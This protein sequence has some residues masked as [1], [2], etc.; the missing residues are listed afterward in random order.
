MNKEGGDF[1]LERRKLFNKRGQVTLFILLAVLVV[2]IAAVVYFLFPQIK[3]F[4][5]GGATTP[6]GFI[7]NCVHDKLNEIVN[8]ISLQGGYVNP[9]AYFEYNGNE[10]AYLCYTN[11]N[12]QACVMQQPLLQNSIENQIRDNLQPTANSCF[13]SL[14]QSY[15]SQ[16]YSVNIQY[17]NTTVDLIP[18]AIVVTFNN[19][20]T[21]TKGGT[22]GY[23]KFS[24]V[25]NNNLYEL[26]GIANSILQWE[27]QYGDADVAT[28]MS[29]YHDIQV[30]KERQSDGTKVYIVTDLTTG[31]KF[32]FATRSFVW[33]PGLG[34]DNI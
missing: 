10:V 22:Q 33:P 26:S 34:A 28:Y 14:V 17:G 15:K 16:G 11:K 25:L 9:P 6:Q 29:L 19:K 21:L 12:Y 1:I 3:S 8:N 31:D 5:T 24:V 4:V 23:G 13:E 32:Q 18:N 30:E 2:A 27:A 20:I 7:Q